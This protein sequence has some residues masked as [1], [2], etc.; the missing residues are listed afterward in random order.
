MMLVSR[1]SVSGNN[2]PWLPGLSPGDDEAGHPA[3]VHG[4]DAGQ[5]WGSGHQAAGRQKGWTKC[6]GEVC[7][8]LHGLVPSLPLLLQPGLP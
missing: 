2:H 3:S 6:Q 4:N 1:R 7:L 5:R 8:G